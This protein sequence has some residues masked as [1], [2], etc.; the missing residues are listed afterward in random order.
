MTTT[1][2]TAVDTPTESQSETPVVGTPIQST[3]PS[4]PLSGGQN[5]ATTD[6]PQATEPGR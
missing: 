6:E 5:T 2:P 1:P 3:T 4:A